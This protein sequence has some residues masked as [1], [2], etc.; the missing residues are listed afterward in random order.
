MADRLERLTNLVAVLLET[1]RPLTL[2]E[3]VERVPGYPAERESYRR[4]FER[5]KATLREIGV[6]ISLEALYAFDQETGYRIHREDYELPPLDLTDDERVALHLAVT[7]VRLE[8]GESAGRAGREALLKL[9]GLEGVAAPT[10]AALPDVPALPALFDA[11]RRRAQV[12]FRYRGGSRRLD[13]YGILF[14]NGHWYVVGFDTGRDAIRAFRADRIESGIEAGPGGAFERPDPFDPATA[15]RDEPWRFG[16][17]EPV[18][19]LVLVSATQ[20]GWVEADLGAQAVAERHDD[21][22]IVVR[23]AVT[24]REAFRSFVLSLLDHAE[25]LA[26]PELRADMFEWLSAL[27]KR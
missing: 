13:P 20:A 22:S 10:L 21:G 6:P 19:A 14:R 4:Q 17:E 3:I 23:M 26:P 1:R 15:L 2:E 9:G 27:A 24:N 25:V 12:T 7:A 16:D 18:E 8:G 11:Y 5:D